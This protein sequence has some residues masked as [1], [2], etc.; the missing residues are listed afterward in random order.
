VDN[1]VIIQPLGL[2]Y[3]NKLSLGISLK[4]LVMMLVSINNYD[5]QAYFPVIV[6]VSSPDIVRFILLS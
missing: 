5:H 4:D 3:N 6:I 1:K 2:H